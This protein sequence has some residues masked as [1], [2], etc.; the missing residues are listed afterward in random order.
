MMIPWS[1]QVQNVVGYRRISDMYTR[2][3][4]LAPGFDRILKNNHEQSPRV[5]GL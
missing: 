1:S 5:R 4:D 3:N 2:M